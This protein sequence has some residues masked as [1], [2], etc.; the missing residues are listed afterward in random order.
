MPAQNEHGSVSALTPGSSSDLVSM[1]AGTKKLRGFFVSGDGSDAVAWVEVDG[2]PLPGVRAYMNVAKHA[3]VV[4]PS[5]E[6]YPSESSVVKLRVKN[7]GGQSADFE[8]V[9]LGE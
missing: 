7:T 3:R 6:S 1:T 9:L 8:G 2:S 5:P 4:L